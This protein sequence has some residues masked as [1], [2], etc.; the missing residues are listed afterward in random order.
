MDNK[1]DTKEIILEC[2]NKLFAQKG[3]D[4]TSIRDSSVCEKAI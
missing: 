4:G 3:F 1:R 2:A